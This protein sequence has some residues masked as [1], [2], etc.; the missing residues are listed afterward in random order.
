MATSTVR[1]TRKAPIW[2]NPRKWPCQL[3]IPQ[4]GAV[5]V[6]PG[7]YIIGRYFAKCAQPPH[8]TSN[9]SIISVDAHAE[10]PREKVLD[11]MGLLRTEAEVEEE[12]VAQ[13]ARSDLPIYNGRTEQGWKTYI[14]R[15]TSEQIIGDY[16]SAKTLRL[17]AK[18]VG[19]KVSK[20]SSVEQVVDSLKAWAE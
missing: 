4:G 6:P 19:L 7:M 20:E 1:S 16:Q 13:S 3:P 8:G 2:H 15:A 17:V 12:R 18:F 11:P 10:I 5:N 9:R 14:A